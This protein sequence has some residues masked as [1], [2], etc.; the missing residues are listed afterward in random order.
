MS[1][2]T[3]IQAQATVDA[4]VAA[5]QTFNG[6]A[7]V[8]M[9]TTAGRRDVEY[10]SLDQLTKAINYWSRLLANLERKAGGYSRHGVS[11]ADF[12]GA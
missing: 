7:R 1:G 4:L 2:I 3:V 10:T 5:A 11:L 9:Q 8:S 6:F 12:T